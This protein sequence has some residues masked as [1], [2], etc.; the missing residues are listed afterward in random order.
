MLLKPKYAAYN[1]R[2]GQSRMV[3]VYRSDDTNPAAKVDTIADSKA[4][5]DVAANPPSIPDAVPAWATYLA[6]PGVTIGGSD[7]AGDPSGYRALMVMQLAEKYY[8]K[9]G[10]YEALHRN[11]TF[12]APAGSAAPDYRFVYE[13]NAL[14]MARSDA[15]VRLARLPA[16]VDLS[17]A[18]KD[19]LYA[20]ATVTI[21]GLAK[22]DPP[23]TLKGERVTWGV[24]MMNGARNPANAIAFLRF[25][26]TPDR[27]VALQRAAGPPPIVPAMV[28]K[29]D[30]GKL[31]AE[32]RP[33]AAVQP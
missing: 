10:L 13:S 29:E 24:T 31:P 33:L 21:P 20:Q 32:L 25:L 12:S 7:P 23:V 9:P 30:G 2:F 18:S 19:E 6:Q 8:G 5:F 15:H 1:I 22:T 26:L 28:S 14:A 3:L 16:E 27:G 17:D 11:Y 4:T